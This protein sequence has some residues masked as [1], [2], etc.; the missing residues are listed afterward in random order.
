MPRTVVRAVLPASLALLA[1]VAGCQTEA[2]KHLYKADEMFE[3]KQYDNAR[4]ELEESIK[5]DPN[6]LDAQK[7]LAHLSEYLGDQQAAA[8]AYQAASILD[9][10]D[11]KLMAKARYYKA[12]DMLEKQADTALA[13]IEAGKTEDGIKSLKEVLRT[14]K[15]KATR[16]KAVASLKKA[17]SILAGKGDQLMKEKKSADALADYEHSAQA[18]LL[19]AQASGGQFE[20]AA[21]AVLRSL[22]AAAKEAGDPEAPFRVLN[23]IL[24]V[25]S[26]N[27]AANRELAQIYLT[28][29]PPDYI[30]AADLEE[31]AGASDDEVKK[32]RDLAKRQR[33]G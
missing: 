21:E 16:E 19:V 33:K 26:N 5:L 28:R 31:R 24:T 25:D 4:A 3:N 17:A 12:L 18:Y 13:D 22:S 15:T 29:K 9:P 7:S 30:T 10:T 8:K 1:L 2:Q 23:D 32:L 6:L 11:L 14:T 27:T 20:P